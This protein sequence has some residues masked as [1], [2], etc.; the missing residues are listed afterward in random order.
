MVHIDLPENTRFILEGDIFKLDSE[1]DDS[2]LAKF[3]FYVPSVVRE[4]GLA[5]AEL[6]RQKRKLE[7]EVLTKESELEYESSYAML[8]LDVA[9]YKN[10]ELRKAGV[11]E[12]VKVRELKG[13]IVT[14]KKEILELES[15]IDDLTEQYWSFKS[16]RDSLESITKL[17]VSERT[18]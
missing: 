17:R 14:K 16:L 13:I 8:D 5:V 9:V 7:G 18:F 11:N 2:M 12:N 4:F 10:E 3:L 6:R 15:D 1:I